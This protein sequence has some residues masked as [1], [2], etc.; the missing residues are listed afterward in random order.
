MA[1][2]VSLA[3]GVTSWRSY[4]LSVTNFLVT[5][6]GTVIRSLQVA[7]LSDGKGGALLT[8]SSLYKNPSDF[9]VNCLKSK[10]SVFISSKEG[11]ILPESVTAP[12]FKEV[13]MSR[14]EKG[15]TLIVHPSAQELA[16]ADQGDVPIMIEGDVTYEGQG[17]E[18]G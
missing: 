4:R 15:F 3:A 7:R 13:L 1:L 6:S 11:S 10:A 18:Y 5:H 17:G 12:E 8:F 2:I 9:S 14:Q 16:L